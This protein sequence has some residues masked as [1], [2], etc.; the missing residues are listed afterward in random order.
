[1]FWLRDNCRSCRVTGVGLAKSSAE[2]NRSRYLVSLILNPRGGADRGQNDSCLT[3]S[4]EAWCIGQVPQYLSLTVSDVKTTVAR[5]VN[6]LFSYEETSEST[7]P[8]LIGTSPIL[9]SI[10]R[11]GLTLILVAA[12]LGLSLLL[13]PFVPQIFVYFFLASVVASAWIGDAGSGLFAVVIASL[14]LD[15]FFLPPLHTLGISWAAVPYFVPFFLSALATA[16][17]NSSRKRVEAALTEQARLAGLDAGIGTALYGAGTL[18][19]GLQGCAEA[20]VRTFD[21]ACARI[22]MFNETT[23]AL[24][25]QARAGEFTLINDLDAR[26]PID[27]SQIGKVIRECKPQHSGPIVADGRFLDNE[28]FKRHDVAAWAGCPLILNDRPIGVIAI[29]AHQRLLDDA[30]RDLGGV[31]LRIGQFIKMKRSEEVMR[32]SE[33]QFR[34]LAEN[35]HEV[36]FVVEPEPVRMVYLSPAYH[37]IWGRS[38]QEVYDRP[39]AWVESVHADDREGVNKSFAD[40]MRGISSEMAYR[41]VRP[42]SSVRWIEARTFPVRDDKGKLTR[43]VGIAEDTTSRRKA[44]FELNIALEELQQQTRNATKLA[45]LVDILQSCQSAEEAF[46]ITG[47]TLQSMLPHTIGAMY[48]TS[49]SRDLVEMVTSWGKD[50]G[51]EAA[52]RPDECWALRRGKAHRL[53]NP[54]S[55]LRCAHI[56][57]A[58]SHGSVCVQ[59][60]AQGETLGML[61]IAMIS[62]A[63]PGQLAVLEGQ[64]MA[65]GERVSLAL[66]NLRL[67]EVLRGQSIRDPLTGLFNRRFMEESLEREL[68]RAVRGKLPV[69]L[70]M[71]DIDHFKHFNDT[72]GHQAGDALLRALG[73]TLKETTRGQDVACRYGGEEFAFVLA[74]A[75]LDAAQKRAEL[76]REEVKQLNVR[77]GGQLLGTVT[78]S[79]GVAVYPESGDNIEQLLKAAD[80]ALYRAKADG[81]DRVACALMPARIS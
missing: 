59:L 7:D 66:A 61:Y 27:N 42:D 41:I 26:I 62:E 45:E 52:F 1:V 50:L 49:P 54:D 79:I 48:I 30:V 68:R 78:I 18:R 24:E 31:A 2:S 32:A 46:K 39:M 55:P 71:L 20:C 14:T 17:M 35:I 74:G 33:E 81:R 11:Y 77:Y 13:N 72:F 58:S 51:S 25:L 23:Q 64:A 37:D 38:P 57:K 44:N 73:N 53:D 76:L 15:Y 12:A 65:V 3:L 22:W 36:F 34:Q 40:S 28:W 47:T 5:A 43:V 60:T 69:A 8:R 9:R 6:P 75:S 21:V 29:F 70:L 16:W 10:L 63:A 80:D 19:E 4:C 67:R 56:S